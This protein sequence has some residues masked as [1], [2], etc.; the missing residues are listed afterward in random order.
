[1][2]LATKILPLAFARS[3]WKTPLS[4]IATVPPLPLI[5]AV[6]DVVENLGNELQVYF[7]TGGH[8]AVATLN[9]RSQVA[10]GDKVR[11]YVDSDQIHLFDSDTGE[12]IF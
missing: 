10:A 3:T 4:S 12:S 5:D 2:P 7:N 1:M 6:V 11:L 9:P 8:N